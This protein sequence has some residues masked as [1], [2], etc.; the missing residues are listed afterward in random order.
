M[1]SKQSSAPLALRPLALVTALLPLVLAGCGGGGGGGGA[2]LQSDYFTSVAVADLDGDG[3]PDIA[4]TFTR[5]SGAPP[6]PG[7]VAV[8]LQRRGQPGTFATPVTFAVGDRRSR[9]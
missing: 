1:P 8:Y 3:L 2:L 5:S 7:F 4:A 9:R 6:H